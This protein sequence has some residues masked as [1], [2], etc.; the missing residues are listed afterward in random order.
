VFLFLGTILLPLTTSVGPIALSSLRI[1]CL[2]VTLP[3]LV[4]VLGGRYGRVIWADWFALIH[5]VWMALSF[6]V[7]EGAKAIEIVGSTGIEF[8]GGYLIARAS[9][10]NLAQFQK[11]CWVLT[12]SVLVLGPFA[13]AEALT[14][15]SIFLELLGKVPGTSTMIQVEAEMRLGL[16]R[17]QS[18]FAHPIHF[19]LFASVS[20]ALSWTALAPLMSTTRRF[21][22]ALTLA[23]AGF[24]SLSSGGI[25]AI[26][27]QIGL[28]I[29][30]TAL[31]SRIPRW[32]MLVGLFVFAYV[33]IDLLS[34][35]TPIR[36][37]M[38]YATFSAHTASWRLLIMEHGFNNVWANPIFGLGLGDWVRPAWMHTPSVDNFWLLA[39]MRNGILGFLTL[40][41]CWL[42]VLMPAM[43]ATFDADSPLG[44]AR[45]AWVFIIIGLCFTLITVHVWGNTFS[46]VMFLLGAGAWFATAQDGDDATANKT[47]DAPRPASRYSRF[48]APNKPTRV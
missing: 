2:V 10:R 38:S 31:P 30:A 3:L 28:I 46:F 14:G 23:F 15:R 29:W 44:H 41:A 9:I 24:L 35:R 34:S 22:I 43:R 33:V 25:L 37:F 8:L 12:V 6:F 45:R 21:I 1:L 5:V 36:V 40:A 13:L 42:A 7:T 11:L 17:V 20:F 32:W 18:V 47:S 48:P 27:L 39:A 19:G 26:G 16:H 4:A